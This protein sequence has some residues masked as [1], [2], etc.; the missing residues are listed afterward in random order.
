MIN[1]LNPEIRERLKEVNILNY[2]DTSDS[3]LY[4]LAIYYELSTDTINTA[5]INQVNIAKI[6]EKDYNNK[7]LIWNIKLFKSEIGE[8]DKDWDWVTT[9]YRKKFSDLN[10]IKRGDKQGTIT[11]MKKYFSLHPEVRKDDILRAAD[12]YINNEILSKGGNT[13]FLMQADY[14]ISKLVS[15]STQSKLDMYIEIIKET[16]DE[17]EGRFKVLT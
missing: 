2:E 9:E 12:T 13:T 17:G 14:F 5:V 8:A 16:T 6:V 3:L 15:G 7:C 11:K 10:P 4:L 1:E